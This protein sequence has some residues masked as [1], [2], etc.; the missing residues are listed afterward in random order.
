[1]PRGTGSASADLPDTI[2][3]PDT[4]PQTD[5]THPSHLCPLPVPKPPFFDGR[6]DVNE[7]V[8]YAR[9][10]ARDR[11]P[12]HLFRSQFGHYLFSLLSERV[13]AQLSLSDSDIEDGDLLAQ[14]LI[15]AY[16][17]FHDRWLYR[18]DLRNAV[19]GHNESLRDFVNRLESLAHHACASDAERPYAVAEAFQRGLCNPNLRTQYTLQK[20]SLAVD[21]S[22]P[23]MKQLLRLAERLESSMSTLP[24]FAH[25]TAAPQVTSVSVAPPISEESSTL[26]EMRKAISEIQQSVSSL[27]QAQRVATP[28]RK[29]H[30][31]GAGRSG[32]PGTPPWAPRLLKCWT[33]GVPGHISQHCTRGPP[34]P[35]P[36]YRQ[37][38]HMPTITECPPFIGSHRPPTPVPQPIYS[39]STGQRCSV[40]ADPSCLGPMF[41]CPWCQCRVSTDPRQSILHTLDCPRN[42]KN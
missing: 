6:S 15:D 33:C 2:T 22:S 26:R 39:S 13:R 40:C 36:Q 32:Q 9:V 7:F 24:Q 3:P 35:N 12:P 8:R 19:Q 5:S 20:D 14:R 25:A 37:Q 16:G 34:P 27:T 38:Q 18:E 29:P 1:M 4:T 41:H 31:H 23:D 30:A 28:S 17:R 42:P 10:L 21:D 11:I